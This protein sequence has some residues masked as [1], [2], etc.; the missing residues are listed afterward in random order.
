MNYLLVFIGGGLGSLMRL[1]T[2]NLIGKQTTGFPLA[3]LCVNLLGA[4]LIGIFIELM[5]LKFQDSQNLRYFLVTGFLG[6][7]TTF[8]AFSLESALLFTRHDYELLALY[9]MASVL[10]T[11]AL[12]LIAI[13]LT[14]AILA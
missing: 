2:S 7:F 10:G 1:A 11:I 8:S 9:I 12:V 6:G 13:N 14:R 5:A 4:F 3:T